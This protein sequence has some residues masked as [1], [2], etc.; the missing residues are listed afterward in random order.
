MQ[1][2]LQV[3]IE[4][5]QGET[6]TKDVIT[7][8]KHSNSMNNIGLSL[9]DSKTLLKNLQGI[10]VKYQAEHFTETHIACPHCH[11]HRRVKGYHDIQY[12]TLFGIVLIPSLRVYR[13]ACEDSTTKTISVLTDWIPNHNHPELQYIETKWASLM[14]YNLTA[15][16]LK[17]ILPVGASLNA[18]T[19]RNHLHRTAKCQEKDLENKPEYISGCPYEW[20]NLPKPGKPLTVGIDG[21]YVRNWYAKKTNFE[22]IT[23]KSMSKGVA[24][25][26]FGFVQTLEDHPRK[27]LMDLLS[28]QGMQANQ[29]ITFLSDGAENLRHLQLRMYPESTHVLDW[30][31]VSMR[32][33][34]LGQFAKGLENSDQEMGVKLK[35]YLE[36]AKWYLWHGN[37][38]ESLNKIEDCS[39]IS[40]DEELHYK[41]KVKLHKYLLEMYTYI[42]NNQCMIPNY[43]ERYRYGE[44]ISTAFVESTVNEVIAKRMVKK[45]QMQ[46]SHQGAHYLIQTRTA[47][48]NNDLKDSFLRWYPGLNIEGKIEEESIV[49][50]QIAA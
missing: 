21:G 3:V 40:E 22:I 44:T 17:D 45:Q 37:I 23:G 5:G 49:D 20:G 18:S 15:D 28:N 26:R 2:T 24:T 32:F 33:T 25:K 38:E 41:K 43:G 11:H 19:V 14:A 39:F 48:L 30:F 31:H 16:L 46:W 10:M 6:H 1:F 47:V 34:V 4:N 36:S 29:Q 7:L 35:R 50:V 8:E 12:R 42:E 13:C 9:S 27:K